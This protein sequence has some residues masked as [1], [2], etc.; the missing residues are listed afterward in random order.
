MPRRSVLTNRVLAYISKDVDDNPDK[1]VEKLIARR[2]QFQ[3]GDRFKKAVENRIHYVRR[4]RRNNP[5]LYL[6]ILE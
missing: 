3:G 6:Q 1:S 2:E 5:R 4:Q